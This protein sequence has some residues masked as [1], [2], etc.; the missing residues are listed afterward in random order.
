MALNYIFSFN[1]A[2]STAEVII[3]SNDNIITN[4]KLE[5]FI[6]YI[7]VLLTKFIEE[8]EEIHETPEKTICRNRDSNLLPPKYHCRA[9]FI[10]RYTSNDHYRYV[11][12]AMIFVS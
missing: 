6:A 5:S 9:T 4:E 10:D 1:G 11:A 2:L 8:T 3:E 7:K 12:D